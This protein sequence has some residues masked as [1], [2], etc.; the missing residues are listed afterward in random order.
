M[1]D[2]NT[3][4]TPANTITLLSG[5]TLS[6]P[7]KIAME[8]AS[9]RVDQLSSLLLLLYGEGGETFRTYGEEMQDRVQWL[10]YSLAEEVR[11]C[12]ALINDQYYELRRENAALIEGKK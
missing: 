7:G 6:V 11:G 5:A 8:H 12:F 4:A 9:M 2:A 3:T 1:A 10:A